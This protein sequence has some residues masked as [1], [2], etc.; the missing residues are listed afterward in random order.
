MSLSIR[1]IIFETIHTSCLQ[2]S[3]MNYFKHEKTV[4]RD[5]KQCKILMS[6]YLKVIEF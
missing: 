2:K 4:I 3:V 6:D 1:K 5:R